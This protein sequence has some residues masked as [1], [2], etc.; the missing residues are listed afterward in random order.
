MLVSYEVCLETAASREA[1]FVAR[2]GH[3][4]ISDEL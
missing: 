4:N 1:D 2:T 3:C